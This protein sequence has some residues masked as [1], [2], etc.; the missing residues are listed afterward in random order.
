MLYLSNVSPT[1]DQSPKISHFLPKIVFC[2]SLSYR[3]SAKDPLHTCFI[4][5]IGGRKIE[6]NAE[7]FS[8]PVIVGLPGQ[9]PGA[10]DWAQQE[11]LRGK[12]QHSAEVQDCGYVQIF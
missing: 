10:P 4:A 5:Q 1:H 11:R 7:V 2:T 8:V 9:L 3:H 6:I 12:H